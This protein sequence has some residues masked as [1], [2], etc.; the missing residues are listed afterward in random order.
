M[1]AKYLHLIKSNECVNTIG[2]QRLDCGRLR[3]RASTTCRWWLFSVLFYMSL[4]LY[5]LLFVNQGNRSPQRGKRMKRLNKTINYYIYMHCTNNWFL[6][7]LLHSFDPSL[8]L[9]F[10]KFYILIGKVI[11]IFD[12]HLKKDQYWS[13]NT[14]YYIIESIF[15]KEIS[16]NVGCRF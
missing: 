15:P 9:S 16:S 6:G 13:N 2:T 12:D 3:T 7:G 10:V 1:Y 11:I 14:N 8:S 5:W 4:P